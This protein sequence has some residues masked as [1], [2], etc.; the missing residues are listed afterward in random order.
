MCDDANS[1]RSNKCRKIYIKLYLLPFMRCALWAS[2]YF[3]FLFFQNTFIH[4]KRTHTLIKCGYIN[5]FAILT[6]HIIKQFEFGLDVV[7]FETKWFHLKRWN[8]KP[9]KMKVNR[10]ECEC[11]KRKRRWRRRM[12][13]R[14]E[15]TTTFIKLFQLTQNVII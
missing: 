14:T 6:F 10:I 4:Y 7:M 12:R 2:I 3:S 5:I 15:I 11:G 8:E 9:T 1:T 13:R